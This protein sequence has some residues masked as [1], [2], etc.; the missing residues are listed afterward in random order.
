MKC[1]ICGKDMYRVVNEK[2]TAHATC[3]RCNTYKECAFC[4]GHIVICPA[5]YAKPPKAP[6]KSKG[7]FVPSDDPI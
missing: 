7:P 1:P 6:P 3:S 5:C 4:D 2:N